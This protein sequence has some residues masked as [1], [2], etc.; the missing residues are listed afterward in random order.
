M[1]GKRGNTW[2]T[3]QMINYIADGFQKRAMRSRLASQVLQSQKEGDMPLDVAM[4]CMA[5]WLVSVLTWWLENGMT[6]SPQQI[7]IWSLL[8]ISR[9]FHFAMGI[10]ISVLTGSNDA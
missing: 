3:A 9:G 10:N 8:F 1:L 2:F 4:A 6:Y 7:G 5:S